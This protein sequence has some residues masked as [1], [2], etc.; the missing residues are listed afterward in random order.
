MKTTTIFIWHSEGLN[1]IGNLVPD[2]TKVRSMDKYAIEIFYSDEDGGFIAIVPELP[3]CS[4]FGPSE[5]KALEEVKVA[6]ELWIEAARGEGRE[7]PEPHQRYH[8]SQLSEKDWER[9][10][11]KV[12]QH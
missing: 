9:N 3:G 10:I 2:T 12:A 7:I 8:V 6:M 11:A 1:T 5:E 4:A